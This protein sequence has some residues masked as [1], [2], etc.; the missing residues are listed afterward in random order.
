MKNEKYF[1]KI[2]KKV[3]HTIFHHK[4]LDDNDKVLVALSGGKDSLVLMETL[5]S[6]K[7]HF[8]FQIDLYACHI[9]AKNI[10]Y[11]INDKYLKSF[12]EELEVPLLFREIDFKPDASGKKHPCFLCSWH[13]R[14][15]L[16][17]L[18]REL[19]CNKLSFGHH[20]DDAIETLFLN[21]IYHGSISSLPQKL[22]LFNG[23]IK[24][25][26]PLL[27]LSENEIEQYAI[28][29]QYKKELKTCEF[30]NNTHRNHLKMFINETLDLTDQNKKNIFR[31]MRNIYHD[32]LP[33]K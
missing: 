29:K 11:Q 2:R 13:R 32:Y 10:D 20:M 22:D 30:E 14:K 24:V 9:I 33:E 4:L 21:M 1:E 3:N 7:K 28:R 27:H 26:R 17:E 12:C 15:K 25:I 6:C 18:C 19:K 23:D 5:A 31:S 16:F 8:P